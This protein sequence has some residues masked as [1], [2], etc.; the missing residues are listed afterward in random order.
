MGTRIIDIIIN[1]L[2]LICLCVGYCILVEDTGWKISLAVFLLFVANRVQH[3]FDS[4][5]NVKE[6]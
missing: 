6:W 4:H 5:R 2:I 3:N 1:I